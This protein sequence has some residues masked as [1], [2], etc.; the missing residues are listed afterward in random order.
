VKKLFEGP[1]AV[2]YGQVYVESDFGSQ[3]MGNMMAA[4]A[5]Q[6]NGLCGA[7]V[8]SGMF[9]MTGRHT[10]TVHFTVELHEVAP[11][12][13]QGWEDVVEVSFLPG[14]DPVALI[15]WGGQR[16]V[17]L[18]MPRVSY[19]VRY[20][21]RGMDRAQE[22]EYEEELKELV[23]R[24]LLQF[25]PEQPREDAIIQTSSECAGYWHPTHRK[26]NPGDPGWLSESFESP[27]MAG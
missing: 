21:A 10:G 19:R 23:D 27:P 24:Y 22:T 17:D 11:A 18:P 12:V 26:P 4:F 9:L 15:E 13:L 20:A 14:P 16:S 3:G 25:W 2:E 8:P 5:G 1:V 7:A 6:L